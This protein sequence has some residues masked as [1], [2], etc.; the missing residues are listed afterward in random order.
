[1]GIDL[2]VMASNFRESRGEFLSTAT[3]RFER[4]A[5]LFSQLGLDASPCLVRPLPPG[6]KVGIY[7]D[8]GLTFVETDRRGE[9]LTFTTP[10]D[11][12]AL[13][14]PDDLDQWNR[15]ILAFLGALSSGA[16][17]LLYWC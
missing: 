5:R 10:G 4:D 13:R 3:L 8:E 17:I 6:L 16:R 9:P 2:K 15:A 14:L 11:L 7:E 12:R 1:M